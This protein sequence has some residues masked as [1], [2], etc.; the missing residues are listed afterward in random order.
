[1][2]QYRI[3][4]SSAPAGPLVDVEST[5]REQVQDFCTGFNTGNFDHCAELFLEEGQL[6]TPDRA[7]VQGIKQIERCLR[8]M[9]DAGYQHLRLETLRVDASG[10]MAMELGEYAVAIRTSNGK[11]FNSRGKYLACWR[12]LGVW[13]MAADCWCSALA[14]PQ[15]SAERQLHAVERP[16]I[17]SR[18]VQRRA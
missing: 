12:R 3:Y 17:I 7:S 2:S 5:I 4:G 11:V 8:D 10:D 6:M 18:D 1:M 9:S 13:R 15:E 16:E 14:A